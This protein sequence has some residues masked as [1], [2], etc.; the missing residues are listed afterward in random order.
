MPPEL[1]GAMSIQN[2]NITYESWSCC[3]MINELVLL[4]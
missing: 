3:D 1:H 2:M 4:R